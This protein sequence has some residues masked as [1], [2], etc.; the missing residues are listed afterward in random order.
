[1]NEKPLSSRFLTI[2][3]GVEVKFEK[4]AVTE[5][6]YYVLKCKSLE[7]D[8]TFDFPVILSVDRQQQSSTDLNTLIKD[9][10]QNQQ[11]LNL[12]NLAPLYIT[13]NESLSEESKQI[14]RTTI[15]DQALQLYT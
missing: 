1:M 2:D 13:K 12:L 8:T 3:Q 10:D 14:I 11:Q 5:N 7:S 4:L 6:T 15:K 9:L